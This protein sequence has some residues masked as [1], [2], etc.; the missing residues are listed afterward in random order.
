MSSENENNIKK[1]NYQIIKLKKK[2][3]SHKKLYGRDKKDI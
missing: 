1:E 2:Y 3:Y